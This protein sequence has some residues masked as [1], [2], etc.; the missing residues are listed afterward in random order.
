[1]LSRRHQSRTVVLPHV[2]RLLKALNQRAHHVWVRQPS[3]AGVGNAN[4]TSMPFGNTSTASASTSDNGSASGGSSALALGPASAASSWLQ[5]L[6]VDGEALRAVMSAAATF[7]AANGEGAVSA[8]AVAAAAAAATAAGL[9]LP[10]PPAA[11]PAPVI[12]PRAPASAGGLAG[13]VQ[14]GGG[15]PG[16]SA[17]GGGGALLGTPV[18]LWSQAVSSSGA[19]RSGLGAAAEGPARGV[20]PRTGLPGLTVV[21][22]SASAGAGAAATASAGAA[23]ATSATSARAPPRGPNPGAPQ[24]GPP[25]PPRALPPA[26]RPP[27]VGLRTASAAAVGVPGA[28]GPAA[29]GTPANGR[30]PASAAAAAATGLTPGLVTVSVASAHA[31]SGAPPSEAGDP[32][33]SALAPTAAAAGGAVA[34]HKRHASSL[35]EA[36]Q[37]PLSAGGRQAAL[38]AEGIVRQLVPPAVAEEEEGEGERGGAVKRR[39]P[40]AGD[41]AE[42][43]SMPPSVA[44]AGSPLVPPIASEGAWPTVAAAFGAGLGGTGSGGGTKPAGPVTVPRGWR[45]GVVN[46]GGAA[47]SGPAGGV[48]GAAAGQAP[49]AAVPASLVPRAWSTAA[50]L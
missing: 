16:L 33:S 2:V 24:R 22:P 20:I 17:L 8:S 19:P 37:Q 38:D 45:T 21:A 47:P 15:L 44:G 12:A 11:A 43:E 3:A 30:P 36:P 39:S 28:R 31:G 49:A 7:A 4:A 46:R 35:R 6:P 10:V 1:M 42:D 18:G 40:R 50:R 41:A 48:G 29:V 9:V 34:G 32:A 26:L 27:A 5:S 25:A 14:G 13:L 23:S